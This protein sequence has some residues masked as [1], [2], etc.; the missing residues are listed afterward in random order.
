MPCKEPVIEPLT[1]SDPV[2]CA[3]P[4]YGKAE[5]P[6][7]AVVVPSASKYCEPAPGL[8]NP[9]VAVTDPV[10]PRDEFGN[11]TAPSTR[12]VPGI[13]TLP[14]LAPKTSRPENLY[15]YILVDIFY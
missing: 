11:V 3:A 1:F 14:D 10:T 6:V 9:V 15:E 7:P 2:I 4:I 12:S 8:I 13:T 5:P